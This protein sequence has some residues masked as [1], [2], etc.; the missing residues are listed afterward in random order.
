MIMLNLSLSLSLSL[1]LWK[2]I[3]GKTI[4]VGPNWSPSLKGLK[5]RVPVYPLLYIW[6]LNNIYWQIL[7]RIQTSFFAESELWEISWS[8][9]KKLVL[10]KVFVIIFGFSEK[11]VVYP[12]ICRVIK[13]VKIH[14]SLLVHKYFQILFMVRASYI[15]LLW[16]IRLNS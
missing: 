1:S 6:I 13:D 12:F 4:G 16:I 11:Q 3:F 9:T 2:H 10:S 5:Y 15:I 8:I 7:W 14:G